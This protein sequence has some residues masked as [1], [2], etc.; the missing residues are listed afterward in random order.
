MRKTL[1]AV[2]ANSPDLRSMNVDEGDGPG[3]C[4]VQVLPVCWRHKVEFP[5]GRRKKERNDE[6]DVA[7]AHEEDDPCTPTPNTCLAGS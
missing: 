5:R 2:Y 4:R 3:N 7:E 6:T 1:K